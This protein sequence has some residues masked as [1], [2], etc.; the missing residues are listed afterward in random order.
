MDLG[1]KCYV[2]INSA[3]KLFNSATYTNIPVNTMVGHV[4]VISVIQ[5][6]ACPSKR[7]FGSWS[8]SFS[9]EYACCVWK[10][11]TFYHA[12]K[13][14]MMQVTCLRIATNAHCYVNNK[15]IHEDLEVRF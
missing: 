7:L 14:Y 1:G 8:S 12:G 9:L 3:R 15:Q 13:L 6:M 2:G 4:R 10:L 5:N 11:A